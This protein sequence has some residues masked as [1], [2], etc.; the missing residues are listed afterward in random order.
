V[1]ALGLRNPWRFSFDRETGELWAGD[2]GG[3]HFEEI[4]RVVRGGNYGWNLREGS[5]CTSASGC[6]ATNV[7]DPVIA[8]AHSQMSSI[9]FGVSYRGSALPGLR[10]HLIYADYASGVV[11]ELD[12]SDRTPSI[13]T[14]GGQSVVSFAEDENGEP[15]LVDLRGS[16]W[17]LLPGLAGPSDVPSLL[18]ATGCFRSGG[19]PAPGLIPYEI[20]TSFWSDNAAKQRWLASP[21]GTKIHIHADGHLELPIGS[22]VAKEFAVDGTRVETRLFVRHAD[23]GWAGYTYRWDGAQR[24]ATLVSSAAS[25]IT[26]MQPKQW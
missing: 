12:P 5:R 15:L 14:S 13:I 7:I 2:V 21:D 1:W 4:D 10:G 26:A 17:R 3:D 11:W 22:V 16:L 8:L 18:S 9:T 20:N 23:G 19:V 6:G 25:G 24:D